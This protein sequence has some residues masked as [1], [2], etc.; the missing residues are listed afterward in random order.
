MAKAKKQK[1]A[2][3][4]VPIP[5][6]DTDVERFIREIGAER[7][8]C[9]RI[10][11]NLSERVAAL[12]VEAAIQAAKHKKRGEEL[13]EGLKFYSEVHRARL[14]ADGGKTKRFAAGSISWRMTNPAVRLK[15]IDGVL[16][17]LQSRNLNKFIRV[18]NEVNKEAILSWPAEVKDVPG[19]SITQREE[20]VVEPDESV[21]D[22]PSTHE[23][24]SRSEHAIGEEV[25][26]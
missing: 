7:R 1:V 22:K 16:A 21:L 4:T 12:T 24:V 5:V 15:S 26:G 8:H 10:A 18:K 6:D 13:F 11:Q 14:C 2:A 17:E 23:T 25:Q 19:I 20:F 3:T 9:L